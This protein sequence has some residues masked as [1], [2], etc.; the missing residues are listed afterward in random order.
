[1]S[2]LPGEPLT[3]I[4]Q[5]H[6]D[7]V[8]YIRELELS[9]RALVKKR[10]KLEYGDAWQ[11][12]LREIIGPKA[13]FAADDTMR[14]RK[15]HNLDDFLHFTQLK[16]VYTVINQSWMIFESCFSISQNDFNVKMNT[17]LPG[18]TDEAHHRPPHLFPS[19]ERKRTEVAAY[20]V[21]KAISVGE[22]LV[23]ESQLTYFPHI[24]A[25][26]FLLGKKAQTLYGIT[27]ILFPS[28]EVAI[29]SALAASDFSD[30]VGRSNFALV[31]SSSREDF[32][33]GKDF[34][35]ALFHTIFGLASSQEASPTLENTATALITRDL[36]IVVT[37]SAARLLEKMLQ[38]L[39]EAAACSGTK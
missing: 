20:D 5:D 30:F 12:R 13:S 38:E 8:D 22:K 16:D 6:R 24:R 19:I 27:R 33:P 10:Y 32:N 34:Q 25:V 1:L 29:S 14:R 17:I 11:D 2:L 9:L 4:E 3:A 35:N 21:L 7:L 23:D 36:R 15:A 31:I 39:R 37:P 26:R 28:D 18:R